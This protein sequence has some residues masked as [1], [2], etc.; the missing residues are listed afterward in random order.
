MTLTLAVA[1]TVIVFVAYPYRGHDLPLFLHQVLRR[2]QVPARLA[3]PAARSSVR[4][5]T[6]M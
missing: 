2:V 4:R 5:R 1:V 6:R 3:E